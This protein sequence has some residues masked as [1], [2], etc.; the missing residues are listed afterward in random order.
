M[1]LIINN[2]LILMFNIKRTIGAIFCQVNINVALNHLNPSRT[3]GNQKWNGAIPIFIS[4]LEFIIIIVIDS[5]E[6]K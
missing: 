3:S 5:C 6:I 1:I 2:N 4:S